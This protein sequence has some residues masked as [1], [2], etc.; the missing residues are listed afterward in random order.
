MN[1]MVA[2][3]GGLITIN[4]LDKTMDYMELKYD[5]NARDVKACITKIL[6]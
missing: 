5:L 6:N 1:L 3:E 4:D 2:E